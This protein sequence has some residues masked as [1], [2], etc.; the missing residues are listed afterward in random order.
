MIFI[1]THTH[2]YLRE[3]K[4]DRDEVVNSALD[5]GI[6]K[7]F[8]PNVDGSTVNAMHALADRYPDNCLPMI[9]L[10]P[11]SVKKDY[12]RELSKLKNLLDTRKYWGI[13]ETGID[14]YW[15]KTFAKQQEESFR[16]HII[17][18]KETGLP[19]VIH[20]RNSF[21]E[22]FTIMDKEN[23]DSLTGIFHAFTGN[24]EQ[25]D[26]IIGYGFKLGI[27]GIVT[28]KNSDLDSVVKDIDLEHIILETDAPYL[29]PVPLRGKRNEPAYLVHTAEKIA[30][31]KKVSL[32]EIAENTTRNAV[33]LFNVKI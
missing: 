14:L 12:T 23:D 9:G 6:L 31:L 27:G 20:A 7:M 10:H 3:F 22:L 28:F 25:A 18:A 32:D 24:K 2:L 8:M 17:L 5:K 26:H 16:D 30:G 33:S 21:D 4:E 15:D 13:G 19:L 1:D 11:T 29:A